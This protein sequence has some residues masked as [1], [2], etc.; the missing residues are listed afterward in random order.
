M[1]IRRSKFFK[2]NKIAR[3]AS[4][5]CSL[6]EICEC[7]LHQIAREIVLLFVNNEHKKTSESQDRRNFESER[8]LFVICTRVTRECIYFQPIRTCV[9]PLA[10]RFETSQGKVCRDFGSKVYRLLI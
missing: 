8:V 6:S 5:I 3:G 4:A 2:V 10:G 1:V 7:S 9:S